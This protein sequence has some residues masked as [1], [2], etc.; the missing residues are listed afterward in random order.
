ML[1]KIL[2]VLSEWGFWGEE[3]VGPLEVLDAAG[4]EVRFATP[5]GKRPQALP[6]SMDTTL[7]GSSTRT[8]RYR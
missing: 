4:Y 5:N 7:C 8:V 2:V 3:L 1:K 6:P